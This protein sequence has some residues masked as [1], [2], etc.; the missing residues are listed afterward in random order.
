VTSHV[1]CAKLR[2]SSHNYVMTDHK[3]N[4]KCHIAMVHT[5]Y[6]PS[7]MNGDAYEYI[8]VY[9]DDIAIIARNPQEIADALMTKYKFKVV[10]RPLTAF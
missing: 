1:N 9:V 8:G 4:V 2:E 5:G 7:Q 6:A 3:K 10:V